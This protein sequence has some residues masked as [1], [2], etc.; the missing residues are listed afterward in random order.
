MATLAAVTVLIAIDGN[1]L[2]TSLG[3]AVSALGN[4]GPGL[5]AAGPSGGFAP[6]SPYVKWVVTVAMLLGRLEP[7]TVFVLFTPRVWRG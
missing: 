5:D 4:V 3:A 2:L 1:S 7:M 6:F